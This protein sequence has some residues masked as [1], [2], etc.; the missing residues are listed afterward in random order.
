MKAEEAYALSRKYTED[1]IE[2]A[3]AVAGKPCQIQSITDITGGHRVTFLWLDNEGAS[4]T[5]AMDV[6]DGAKGDKG[7]SGDA[8]LGIK[9]VAVN[10]EDHLIITYD[11]DTTQDAG[12]IQITAA[13]DSVNG[14]TGEV[15]LSASDVGALPDDTDIPSK[16]SDLTNDSIV[17][18]ASY[19]SANHQILFKNGTTTLFSLD[20][21]AFVKDGMVDDVEISGGNLVITFNTDAGKQD[22][23]IPLTDIFDPANY[24]DKDDVDGLLADK[25]DKVDSATNGNFAG[26]DANGN[27]TDSGKKAGDFASP[28]DIA[29][30]KNL[31]KDTVGWTG[32]N[33][34][35]NEASTLT[36]NGITWTV[37][38]DGTILI[39]GTNTDNSYLTVNSNI[40]LDVDT[41]Y[42]LSGNTTENADEWYLSL[43]LQVGYEGMTNYQYIFNNNP[44][45]VK[46]KLRD[47]IGESNLTSLRCY[48]RVGIRHEAQTVD[49]VTFYPMI[50]RADILDDTYE[51]YHESVETMYEEEIH[52]VNLLK[53][54]ASSSTSQGITWTVNADG[55]IKANGTAS[56][57]SSNAALVLADG[58]T[59]PVGTYT[60]TGGLSTKARVACRLTSASSWIGEDDGDG[61]T[62]SVADPAA[63]HTFFIAILNGETVSNVVFKPMLRKAT[64]EDSTYRPY[65]NQAIQNQLNDKG[66]LGAK[67]RLKFPY[68][69]VTGSPIPVGGSV[70][71]AGITYTVNADG[72]ITANG[73]ATGGS[74]CIFNRKQDW[75]DFD[76]YGKRV[77]LSVKPV[78]ANVYIQLYDTDNSK[79]LFRTDSITGEVEFVFPASLKNNTSW[80]ISIDFPTG[81]EPNNTTYYSML[82]LASDPDDTYQPYAM[83]NKQLTDKIQ[84]FGDVI[85]SSEDD[86][87]EKRPMGIYPFTTAP[88]HSPEGLTYGVLINVINGHT[89]EQQYVMKGSTGVIYAR[90]LATSSPTRTWTS[91]FKFT[92]TVVS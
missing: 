92:G 91:W 19:D 76:L 16:T 75:S 25:A 22:I 2:G 23:S 87:D 54:T 9:S 46:F 79:T 65:N 45:G 62:F 11:D 84:N 85:L 37:N 47:L 44:T 72:S 73:T 15:V 52:G 31:L 3:G 58:I 88:L 63:R 18:S 89:N 59:F 60:L 82:R 49:N 21:A 12:Q 17:D 28:A 51:P 34:L 39:N 14:K 53:V 41:E 24:Y 40:S 32:K 5:S 20:A 83:T 80:N 64:I 50:R 6:M 33:L 71:N 90:S 13:V 43:F 26:L 10:A 61:F 66:V 36:A 74:Y 77:K 35:K 27:L 30:Q 70:E 86:M 4:H 57:S 78:S 48:A 7:D 29:G 56:S 55:S 81:A 67:N 69:H 38:D 8:G 42:I 68:C 1:T